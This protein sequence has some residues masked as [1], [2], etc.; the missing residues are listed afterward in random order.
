MKALK[1]AILFAVVGGGSYYLYKKLLRTKNETGLPKGLDTNDNFQQLIK[2]VGNYN[3]ITDGIQIKLK[4]GTFIAD[5][6]NNN[7]LVISR[8]GIIE[9][10]IMKGTYYDGGTI[11]SIDKKDGGYNGSNQSVWTNLD[12]IINQYTTDLAK[13]VSSTQPKF[14]VGKI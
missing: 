4:G 10:Y 3:T 12:E 14:D 6:Y 8:S 7:R 11:I 1:W 5:I 2:K 13:Q 9:K